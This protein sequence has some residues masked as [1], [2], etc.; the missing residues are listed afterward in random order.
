MI[1]LYY[2]F[3][4]SDSSARQL[5]IDFC[6]NK[7]INNKIFDKIFVVISQA[8]FKNFQ[9]KSDKVETFILNKRPSFQDFIEIIDANSKNKDIN[10]FLNSDCFASEDS[11]KINEIKQDEMWCLQKYEII[12]KDLN[13]K[14][15]NIDCSQDVWIF[16]GKPKP[17]C[18]VNFSFG[19]SGCDNRFA[20]ESEKAGYLVSNPSLDI[21][22][23]H[24]HL[25]A[26][27]TIP[28]EIRERY[29]IRGGY[30]MLKPKKIA[31]H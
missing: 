14:F 7:N 20:F 30:K 16:R 6:L 11:Y 13:Y 18:N 4:Y 15:L 26:V 28:I 5:E 9:F 29:R 10:V 21:K 25:S 19:Y 31:G 27:R 22:F 2:N 3:Y 24:Y 12:D 17:I 8:D 23:F 1:I